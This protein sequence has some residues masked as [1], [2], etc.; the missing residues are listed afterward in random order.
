MTRDTTITVD[1]LIAALQRLSIDGK[2]HYRVFC[3]EY[4]VHVNDGQIDV[5]DKCAQL[6][7]W[8]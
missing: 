8:A 6:E 2:G 5:S 3:E 4:G 1:E 7:G